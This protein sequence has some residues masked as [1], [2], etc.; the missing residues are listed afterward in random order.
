MTE[1]ARVVLEDC[2]Q[3]L[4]LLDD[5][6][7]RRLWRI[8]WLGALTLLRTVGD[9]LHKVDCVGQPLKGI[10][11]QQYEEWKTDSS[12]EIF[13]KFIKFERDMAVHEYEFNCDL[14][15]SIPILYGAEEI[16][17]LEENLFRPQLGGWRAGEDVRDIYHE[18]IDWWQLQLDRIDQAV[19]T[20]N[21]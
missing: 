18:A 12:A 1:V 9:V 15:S 4:A 11:S 8:H 6:A 14:R 16:A 19:R 21:S 7:D 20:T 5:L 2:R 17:K 3:A 13:F 10:C